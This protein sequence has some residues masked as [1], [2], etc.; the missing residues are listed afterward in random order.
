MALP[1]PKIVCRDLAGLVRFAGQLGSHAVMFVCVFVLRRAKTAATVVALSSQL[2][3]PMLMGC[4]AR[5][6]A[7]LG[8][9]RHPDCSGSR[10]LGSRKAGKTSPSQ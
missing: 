8:S 5:R 6:N 7:S 9:R 3:V 1:A 10:S 4:T 2:A